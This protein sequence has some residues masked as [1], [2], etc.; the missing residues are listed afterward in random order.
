M[1]SI[2]EWMLGVFGPYGAAGVILFVALIFFIDAVFFPTLPELFFV[3]GFMYMPESITFGIAL[4]VA[5]SIG[6]VLGIAL[7]YVIVER[8]RMPE[9]IKKVASK[10]IGFLMVSDERIF[11]VNRFAPMVP[12]AGA[13]ISMVEGWQ[14]RKCMFYIVLGCYLKF[15]VILLFSKFFYVFFSSDM[16]QTFTIIMVFV[17]IAVSFAASL[18]KRKKEGIEG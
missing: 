13:F 6:E 12:F 11:L 1:F 5:A 17:I 3:I 15:G 2:S 10:Y 14:F 4:L 18:L 7:L 16:A 8:I 9:R